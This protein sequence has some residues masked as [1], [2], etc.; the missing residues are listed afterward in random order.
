MRAKLVVLLWVGSLLSA[1]GGDTPKINYQHNSSNGYYHNLKLGIKLP[2]PPGWYVEDNAPNTEVRI[3]PVPLNADDHFTGFTVYSN[4]PKPD[5]LPTLDEYWQLRQQ[6]LAGLD[7]QWQL[8]NVIQNN[9]NN[10]ATLQA[11]YRL[12]TGA[13]TLEQLSTLAVH[14]G[15]GLFIAMTARP[16]VFAE[17]KVALEKLVGKIEFVAGSPAR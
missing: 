6:H 5:T 16:Q 17:H 15:R 14:H 13:Q 9:D 8:V 4:R 1:C 7:S 10:P 3:K 2:L 11:H 12:N